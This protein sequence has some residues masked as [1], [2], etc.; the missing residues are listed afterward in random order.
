[1]E[2]M[3]FGAGGWSMPRQGDGSDGTH[4]RQWRNAR[5]V[6]CVWNKGSLVG[7]PEGAGSHEILPLVIANI[8][9]TK[10]RTALTIG[11][12]TVALFLFGLLVIVRECIQPGRGHCRR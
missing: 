9:G 2:I 7:A 6:T 10:M 3:G 11:S 5:S 12:F 4:D 1:M 8:F